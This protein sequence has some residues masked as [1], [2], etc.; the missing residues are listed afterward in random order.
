M[1]KT[2]D[3]VTIRNLKVRL[4][5]RGL[6][7]SKSTISKVVR[8]KGFSFQTLDGCREAILEQPHLVAM[9]GRYLRKLREKRDE[10]L[11]IVYLDTLLRRYVF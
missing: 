8:S 6:H 7:L 5:E 11:D 9:R 3:M 4:E 1:F 10:G 2:Q